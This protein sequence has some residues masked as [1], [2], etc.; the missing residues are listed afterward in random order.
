MNFGALS[1]E[2]LP[3]DVTVPI[4]SPGAITFGLSA[5][6]NVGEG[7]VELLILE[8][9]ENGQFSDFYDFVERVPEVVLNKRTI[10]SLIKGGGFDALGH[11]S[12]AVASA[13]KE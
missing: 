8:R 6:R 13:K 4:G 1:P 5:V 9:T 10:E 2:E 12:S 11:P 7:L 3:R